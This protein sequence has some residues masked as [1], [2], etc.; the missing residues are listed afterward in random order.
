GTSGEQYT[1]NT[2][3]S[4]FASAY[5]EWIRPNGTQLTYSGFA[6]GT[7]FHGPVTL[8][9]TGTWKIRIDP[10]SANTGKTNLDIDKVTGGGGTLTFGQTKTATINSAGATQDYTIN[11]TAGQRV[12][13]T[14]TSSTIQSGYLYFY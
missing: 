8:D 2:T 14:I 6:T 13:A 11:M 12:T 7:A 3:S 5:V 1:A 10:T 4:T 9:A